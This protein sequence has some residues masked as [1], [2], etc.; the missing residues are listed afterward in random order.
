[1]SLKIRKFKSPLCDSWTKTGEN[2]PFSELEK[3]CTVGW[4]DG[5]GDKWDRLRVRTP[6]LNGG[7]TQWGE[8]LFGELLIFNKREFGTG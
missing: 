5:G 3:L 7:Q 8:F 2:S 4:A 6:I 1:M